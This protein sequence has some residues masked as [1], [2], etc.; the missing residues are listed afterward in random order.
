MNILFF[1]RSFY[2]DFEA[3]GQFLT[4]LCEDLIDYG[5]KVTVIC[6]TSYHA[7]YK[8]TSFHFRR[9]NYKS[10]SVIRAWSTKFDKRF[11]FLRLINL[12]TYFL[13]AFIAGFLIKKRPDIVVA[14]T[15]PPVLGLL[16]FFF[17]KWY[18][19]KF[20]YSCKDIYPEVGI[21]TGKLTNPF[22]NYLLDKINRFSFKCADK[23]LCLGEVMRKRI[24]EKGVQ[25]EKIEILPD[26]TDTKEFS[27]VSKD[28]NPFLSKHKLNNGF[29]LMYSG[30]IGLTQSLDK[31]LEVAKYFNNKR[32][33]IRFLLVGDGADKSALEKQAINLELKNV[34]FLPYQPKEELKYSLSA[35][36]VHL[37]TF[38]KGLAGIMVPSKVY[39][40]L[41]CGKPFIA[42]VDDESEISIIAKKFNCGLSVSSGNVEKMKE[43]IEW[44]MTHQEE[45]M[46][47][48]KNGRK[49]AVEHFDRK[50]TTAK[51]NKIIQELTFV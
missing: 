28:E 18:G 8:K 33:D 50:L 21:I 31:I 11:L 43:A 25:S 6:G 30:N 45:L 10:I 2:P 44:S 42:W 13:L 37:I 7:G 1:N 3:T 34:A 29:K 4:E 19:A 51:F 22:L 20:I 40:I 35:A 24:E 23:V 16:G 46:E 12:G 38:Q 49:A 14:Q 15:D 9:E 41:A 27:F 47:M 36:D 5:H 48:G 26:W 39:N 17:S 32:K